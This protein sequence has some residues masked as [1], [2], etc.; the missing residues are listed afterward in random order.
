MF[1][2]LFAMHSTFKLSIKSVIFFLLKFCKQIRVD[3][4]NTYKKEAKIIPC[5]YTFSNYFNCGH[6]CKYCHS[7]SCWHVCAKNVVKVMSFQTLWNIERL[8][9]KNYIVNQHSKFYVIVVMS[10]DNCP[11]KMLGRHVQHTNSFINV[12]FLDKYKYK[13]KMYDVILN[14]N[15]TGFRVY[16]CVFILHN[17]HTQ[18][19]SQREIYSKATIVAQFSFN[20]HF[21][22]LT[23]RY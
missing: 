1:G 21:I 18:S 11:I 12:Q 16:K 19:I 2:C 22:G 10:S 5:C 8:I 4:V 7:V 6:K 23:R 20:S 3:K 17:I 14:T 15:W 9:W 13:T